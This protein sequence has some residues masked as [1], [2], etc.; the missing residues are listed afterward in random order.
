MNYPSI[1]KYVRNLSYY[2]FVLKLNMNGPSP[3]ATRFANPPKDLSIAIAMPEE[4]LSTYSLP[5]LNWQ[6]DRLQSL[7]LL[8]IY[9][10]EDHIPSTPPV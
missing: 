1:C 8:K 4:K 3:C 9:L 6:S 7:L 10:A 2:G 5:S